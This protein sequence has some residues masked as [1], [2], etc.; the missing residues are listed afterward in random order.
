[1]IH[2]LML[3][4]KGGVGKT[5]L[6]DEIAFSFERT[7]QKVA[8]YDLDGQGGTLH[9]NMTPPDDPEVAVIDTPGALQKDMDKWIQESDVIVVPTRTY[10]NEIKPLMRIIT[11]LDRHPD[12]K[13]LFVL[14]EFNGYKVASTFREWI[15]TMKSESQ[16]VTLKHYEQIDQA[17]MHGMSVVQYATSSDAS[18]AVLKVVNKV[19]K[20]AGF[21]EES[22]RSV[23]KHKKENER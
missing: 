7:G 10:H 11:A 13:V 5:L 17:G 3:N 12:K 23:K 16:V 18:K 9:E 2:I 6:A 22:L 14:N 4:Q 20:L 8:F 1:M 21:P 19:R 15:H